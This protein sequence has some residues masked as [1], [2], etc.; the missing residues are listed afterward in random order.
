MAS[1]CVV[2]DVC[3]EE[4]FRALEQWL[5]ELDTYSTRKD[6][7]KMLVGNKIDKSVCYHWY[8]Y[9]CDHT[10]VHHLQGDRKVSREDGMSFARRNSMLFIEARYVYTHFLKVWQH[11]LYLSAKTKD[12][13]QQA[14]EELVHKILQTPGLFS[15]NVPSQTTVVPGRAS[16]RSSE[17]S[18]CSGNCSLS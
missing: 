5:N 18:W 14:F 7:V 12:G 8:L 6:L 1:P 2:Y 3:S 9:Q 17:Q 16:D 4:S 13:V 15:P 10:I 11:H